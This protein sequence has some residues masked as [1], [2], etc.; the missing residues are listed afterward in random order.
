M[1]DHI[2]RLSAEKLK[3]EKRLQE[4]ERAAKAQEERLRKVDASL[5]RRGI[6]LSEVAPPPAPV[7]D[8]EKSLELNEFISETFKSASSNP[9]HKAQYGILRKTKN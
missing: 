6:K 7:E 5:A 3:L 8:H 2:K 4:A 9:T 1:A